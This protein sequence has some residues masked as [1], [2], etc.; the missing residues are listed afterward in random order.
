M[1]S[2][3]W[4]YRTHRYKQLFI[5]RIKHIWSRVIKTGTKRSFFVLFFN[6]KNRVNYADYVIIAKNV[7]ILA[8]RNFI[9][10]SCKFASRFAYPRNLNI[11]KIEGS[12]LWSHSLWDWLLIRNL[13]QVRKLGYHANSHGI[14]MIPVDMKKPTNIFLWKKK[15]LEW[16]QE[17][18]FPLILLRSTDF[19]LRV[20][21]LP[22]SFIW[23]LACLYSLSQNITSDEDKIFF[24][25]T[26]EIRSDTYTT[27][28]TSIHSLPEHLAHENPDTRAQGKSQTFYHSD[29]WTTHKYPLVI[30]K[31]GSFMISI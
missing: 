12:N 3:S 25:W 24:S 26:T 14:S 19:E 20:Q 4:V 2:D 6:Q 10:L 15:I 22:Y 8:L 31:H 13:L 30:V 23:T 17:A 5:A 7:I 1:S 9:Q 18:C 28:F 21:A 27:W 29:F 11:R 16:T